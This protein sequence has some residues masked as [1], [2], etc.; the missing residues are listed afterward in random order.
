MINSNFRKFYVWIILLIT[1]SCG[2]SKSVSRGGETAEMSTSTFIKSIDTQ[3]PSFDNLT[4]QSNINVEMPKNKASLSG[5]IY[6]KNR[7]KIWVNISKFG[8]TAAR[9]LITPNGFKAYE[10]LN[11]TYVDGDYQFVN[12]LL[13]VDFIDYQKLQNLMLGRVFTEIKPTEFNL[14]IA[15]NRYLLTYSG[16]DKIMKNPKQ[17]KYFQEYIFDANFRLM[18]AV[19]K[20]PFSGKILEITYSGWIPVGNQQF[21]KDVKIL[22]KDKKT[23]KV[24]L[25]YNNF[26]F[27]ESATP[28]EIPSGYKPHDVLK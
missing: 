28:F 1:F 13:K 6:I 11:R 9:A 12:N 10:K 23:K 15:D 14:N 20:D 5:K 16:N 25:E 21:P 22:V 27:T 24:E 2:T 8:L 26:T 4:I 18:H 19:V 3:K 7:E 17:G